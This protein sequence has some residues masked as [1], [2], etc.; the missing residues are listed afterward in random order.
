M[1]TVILTGGGSRR[2]GRDKAALP[3]GESTFLQSLVDKYAALGPVAVSV[4]TPGRFAF[5][6]AAELVDAFPG[7]GPLNG[8]VSGFSRTGA[9]EVFLTG[10]DLPLGEPELARRLA[11]LRG[12]A[13]ACVLRRGA[14]GVEPLFAVYGR[15]CLAA[16]RA[17]L[18]A[19]ERSFLRMLRGVDVRYAA[20]EEVPGFDLDRVLLNVNTPGDYEKLITETKERGRI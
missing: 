20:P 3:W 15:G 2:M 16:A 19:G 5:Q 18:E 10:T 14:K 17:A 7:Q 4:D 8:L 1:L 13:D 12:G 9:E 11:L 6:G